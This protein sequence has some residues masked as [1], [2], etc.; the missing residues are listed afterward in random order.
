MAQEIQNIE[1]MFINNSVSI[2]TM[3]TQVN[4]RLSDDLLEQSEEYAKKHGF[5]NVQE[6]IKETLREKVV[7]KPLITKKELLLVKKL[8]ELTKERN[9]FGTEDEL[10]KKIR[11]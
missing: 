9:L 4:V 6:L 2:D 5:G 7:E 1:E 11:K 10:F 8:A 3:N